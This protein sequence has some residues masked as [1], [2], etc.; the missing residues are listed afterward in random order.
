LRAREV[1]VGEGQEEEERKWSENP[2]NDV[3][4]LYCLIN[5]WRMGEG[6]FGKRERALVACLYRCV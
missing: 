2:G 4:A 3:A 5:T 6:G 1:G